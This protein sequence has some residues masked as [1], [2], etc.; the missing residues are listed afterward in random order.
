MTEPCDILIFGTGSF[1]Q[2][3]ACDLAATA[4]KPTRIA[5]AGRNAVRLAWIRTAARARADMFARPVDDRDARD[6]PR[7]STVAPPSCWRA[8]APAVIVQAASF[9][10]GL[11]HLRRPATPG[12]ASLR[13]AD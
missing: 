2:R 11:G 10:T 8:V 5:I 9:Q 7:R 13:K 6:R 4:A 3:I 1:A 12:R